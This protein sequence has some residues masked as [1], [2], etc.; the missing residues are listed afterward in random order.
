MKHFAWAVL[1]LAPVV[2]LTGCGSAA[3]TAAVPALAGPVPVVTAVEQIHRPIDP[4]LPQPSEV[5]TLISAANVLNAR[6]MA[7]FGLHGGD[8]YP[9]DIDAHGVRVATAHTHLYGFFDPSIVG[10]DGYD[11][12][13]LQSAQQPGAPAPASIS[14]TAKS[15]EIGRDATGHPVTSYAGKP[16][17]AHGC[18]AQAQQGIG[19]E[20]PDMSAAGLPA[21]GPPVP[22]DDPRVRDVTK[23]W[24]ACMAGKGY[25]FTTAYDAMTSNIAQEAPVTGTGDNQK[26]VHSAAEIAQATTDL[27]CKQATNFMGIATAVQDAYDQQ[28]IAQHTQALA[29]YRRQFDD[30]IHA[31]AQIVASSGQPPSV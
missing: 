6:C 23:K 17:P 8:T 25:H 12:I 26:V 24:S 28:Y 3:R 13:Q 15:V 9:T 22:L 10:T 30:R 18:E 11:L 20:L 19:G 27:A 29:D 21:G 4:Y 31:A 5:R 16:V 7:G 2:L 14:D 1:A